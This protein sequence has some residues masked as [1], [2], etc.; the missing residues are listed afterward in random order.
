MLNDRELGTV[1]AALRAI[2]NVQQHEALAPEIV[3]IAT[4]GGRL[5]PLND[6]EIDAL[7][8]RLQK[9]DQTADEHML[10]E[11][12][13]LHAC[14]VIQIDA[15]APISPADNGTWVQAWVLVP[16]EPETAQDA[17]P[18]EKCHSCGEARD[19]V[20]G[21]THQQWQ[22]ACCAAWNDKGAEA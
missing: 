9:P 17:K 14:D 16:G 6:D 11:A 18:V 2:Q 1:L 7:C 15:D 19:A 3:E 8:E 10:A 12:I 5:E 21:S 4:D 20:G 13:Q 22:C